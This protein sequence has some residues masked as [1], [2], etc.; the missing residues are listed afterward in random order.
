MRTHR[1]LALLNVGLVAAIVAL[2][3]LA[4]YVLLNA[5]LQRESDNALDERIRLAERAWEATL[6]EGTPAIPGGTA[7]DTGTASDDEG[8]EDEEAGEDE[9]SLHEAL[10]TGDILIFVYGADGTLLGS[11]HGGTAHSLDTANDV[12]TALAG[13]TT[14]R[15]LVVNDEPVRV[16]TRPVTIDGRIAGVIQ[17]MHSDAEHRAELRLVRNVGLVGLGLGLLV[18]LPVGMYLT[19][20]ALLPMATAAARQRRFIADASHELKTPLSVIRANVELIARDPAMP[21]AERAAE[22]KHVLA[23]VDDMARMIGSLVTLARLDRPPARAGEA[24][25]LLE[26]AREFTRQLQPLAT[27]AG[28]TLAC[29]GEETLVAADPDSVRQVLRIVVENA[30]A[31]TPRGGQVTIRVT[32]GEGHA[33]LVVADTGIG[34]PADD[35]PRVF[36][37]FYR[38][39]NAAAGSAQGQGLGL[40]IARSLAEAHGGRLEAESEAGR[41]ST[42]RLTLP[43]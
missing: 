15:S 7:G 20:R 43:R 27:Q 5:S 42:F 38:A 41:G 36:D 1:R 33:R 13:E 18:A 16:R 23:E 22:L 12:S 8:D 2:V 6:R 11:E 10:E 19:H 37:R 17:A 9:D 39:S 26:L 32:P 35:L 21:P 4:I 25:R 34:I 3:V 40:Y 24:T 30:I 14:S 28:L 29:E 31:Y